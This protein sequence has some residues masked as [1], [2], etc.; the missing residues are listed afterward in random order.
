MPTDRDTSFKFGGI[1]F[2]VGGALFLTHDLLELTA[3]SPPP[4]GTEILLWVTTN[5]LTLSV[6]NEV[7]F[8]ACIALVPAVA[9]LYRSLADSPAKALVATGCG[10]LA[11]VVPIIGVLLIIHG[12]LV[13]PVFGLRIRDPAVAEFAVAV[14]FGGIH[15][16]DLLLAGATLVLSLAMRRSAFGTRT[17]ALGFATT[18]G[19]IVASYP[20]LIGPIVLVA[21]RLLFVAWLVVIGV[22]LLSVRE[23]SGELSEAG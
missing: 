15:A 23:Q 2:I 1:A 13:Y 20:Y 21:C 8:F 4:T 9:A 6:I 5:R 11:V 3:G 7:L 17:V 14:F 19:N 10:I 18:A 16:V 12:R 22:K